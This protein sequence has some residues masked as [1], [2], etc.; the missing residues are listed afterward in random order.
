MPISRTAGILRRHHAAGGM[1]AMWHIH[2]AVAGSF[3]HGG[4]LRTVPPMPSSVGGNEKSETKNWQE[5]GT[6]GIT[7]RRVRAKHAVEHMINAKWRIVTE[8]GGGGRGESTDV[9]YRDYSLGQTMLLW[10]SE[11]RYREFTR[12]KGFLI[13]LRATCVQLRLCFVRV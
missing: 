7:K 6:V 11:P 3:I 10:V 4:G 2:T 13:N 8:R 1:L 12:D 5:H 9:D